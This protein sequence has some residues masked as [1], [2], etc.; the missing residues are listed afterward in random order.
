M[1]QLL[2]EAW[3]GS[4]GKAFRSPFRDDRR[5]S[6]SVF[7][8]RSGELLYVDFATGERP[9]SVF[10]LLIEHGGARDFKA[11]LR[12]AA[13]LVGEELPP[14][15][16]RSPRVR[17]LP[18]RKP[19][20]EPGPP[21]RFLPEEDVRRSLCSYG[22]NPFACWLAEVLGDE[23]RAVRLLRRYRAG[24]ARDG[25]ALFFQ[26]DPQGR[27]WNAKRVRYGADGRRDRSSPPRHVRTHAEGY[28]PMLFGA[29][30][31]AGQ[32]DGGRVALVESEKT[33]LVA[34]AYYP[35]MV[36][37]ATGGAGGLSRSLYGLLEG[38]AVSLFPD[39]DSAGRAAYFGLCERLRE[40][41]VAAAVNTEVIDAACLPE[42]G[43][44]ADVLPNYSPPA[45]AQGTG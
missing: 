9:M 1:E 37:L 5:P 38:F 7:A 18:D 33:A 6:A 39:N 30:L 29:H 23:G 42:K 11:A 36:W 34:S 26:T 8:G 45:E 17:R 4:L 19:L 35:R 41:G 22:R 16:F 10:D 21:A 20:G 40:A 14:G 2:G 28:K 15:G 13:E 12:M 27:T 3:P 24:T 43:D 31:L 44:L 25:D 32:A